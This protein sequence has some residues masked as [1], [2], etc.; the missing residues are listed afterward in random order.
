MA[1]QTVGE[2]RDRQ[3]IGFG[4]VVLLDGYEVLRNEESGPL[5]TARKEKISIGFRFV[6]RRERTAIGATEPGLRPFAERCAA[7]CKIKPG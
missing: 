7:S 5:R 2:Q 6:A 1:S 3:G 4:I